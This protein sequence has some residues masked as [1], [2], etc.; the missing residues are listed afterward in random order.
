MA[1]FNKNFSAS[2]FS[3]SWFGFCPVSM[4]IGSLKMCGGC[5]LVGYFGKEDQKKDWP[6]HKELC[7][8]VTN[9]MKK[10]GIKHVTEKVGAGVST[11]Q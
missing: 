8:A 2:S 6:T 4:K 9:L 10:L 11:G 3:R 1:T 7:K 5:K